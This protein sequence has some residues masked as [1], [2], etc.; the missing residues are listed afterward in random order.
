M[1]DKTALIADIT[2]QD[3]ATFDELVAEL[4]TSDLNAVRADKL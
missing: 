4:A 1:A 2:G 3:G